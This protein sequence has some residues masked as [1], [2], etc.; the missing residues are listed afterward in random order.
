METT[1]PSYVSAKPAKYALE[2][3]RGW[4]TK[5]KIVAGVKFEM[6]SSAKKSA[7]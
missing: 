2:M 4:F 3:N 6:K 1:P 5:N 7:K